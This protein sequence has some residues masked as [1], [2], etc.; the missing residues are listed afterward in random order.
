VENHSLGIIGG[1]PTGTEGANALDAADYPATLHPDKIVGEGHP[2]TARWKQR[3]EGERAAF[4]GRDPLRAL[5][6]PSPQIEKIR[7]QVALVANSPLTALV[8]GET[9]TGKEL[10]ARGIHYLS[11]RCRRPFIALD[12]GAIPEPLIESELF[13]YERGA[14]TGADQRKE[15]HFQL[16]DGGSLLLDEIV[17]LPL[18]TQA[19][20]LRALQERVVRPLGGRRPT[21]VDVRIIAT[22]NVPLERE[23]RAGRFR[24]DLY[25]RLNEFT[26]TLPALRERAEDILYLADRFLAEASLEFGRPIRG[27]SA[28]AAL[29][30]TQYHWPGNVRQLRSLIRQAVLLARD[31]IQPEHLVGLCAENVSTAA[32]AVTDS[33]VAPAGLKAIAAAAAAD[34]ERRAIRQA[35]RAT[36]GN[37]SAVARLLGVDYKTLLLKLKRYGIRGREFET[38]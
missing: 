26:I 10:I 4:L 12:C 34:A 20:L 3:A 31:V 19:K 16:A 23:M 24:Q 1:E 37:K 9:G 27:I 14:F 21:P 35:L 6:G 28:E 30:L 13:G 25:Y 8:Q 18:I 17:N 5:M 7:R 2:A 11:L 33:D 32:S 22:S 36:K 38:D 29:L 15:G